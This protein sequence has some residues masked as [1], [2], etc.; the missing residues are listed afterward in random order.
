MS[1]TSAAPQIYRLYCLLYQR[2]K[3]TVKP[4]AAVLD[5]KCLM[6]IHFFFYYHPPNLAYFFFDFKILISNLFFKALLLA[7]ISGSVKLTCSRP[8]NPSLNQV[9]CSMTGVFLVGKQSS[10]LGLLVGLWKGNLIFVCQNQKNGHTNDRRKVFCFF[11]VIEKLHC[12]LLT[13]NPLKG[14][15]EK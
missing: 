4:P 11:E 3:T 7:C 9:L 13:V 14:Q 15:T 1:L 5:P 6:K 12:V 2:L 8:L 10:Q